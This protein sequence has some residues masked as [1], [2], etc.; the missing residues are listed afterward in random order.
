MT[1]SHLRPAEAQAPWRATRCRTCDS[2]AE[3][4][5]SWPLHPSKLRPE[6]VPY[7]PARRDRA[8]TIPTRRLQATRRLVLSTVL[9]YQLALL[10]C[11][12]SDRD[13]RVGLKPLLK[14]A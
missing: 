5:E 8:G 13:L 1:D 14:A 12:L 3:S 6:C 10:H 2:D 4:V 11:V 7:P 9:V